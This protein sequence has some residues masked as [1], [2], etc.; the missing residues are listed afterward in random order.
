MRAFAL[1]C[2]CCVVVVVGAGCGS[3]PAVVVTLLLKEGADIQTDEV[4]S[5]LVRVGQDETGIVADR[6]EQIAIELDAPP[7]DGDTE[8]VVFACEG[9]A[10]CA[11]SAAV[12]VGCDV[13]A[14]GAGVTEVTVQVPLFPLATPEDRCVP[15]IDGE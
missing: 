3:S 11:V 5:L 1:A 4:K 15:L 7:A 6:D 12:F 14:I 9:N 10:A 13:A 8:F 2:A